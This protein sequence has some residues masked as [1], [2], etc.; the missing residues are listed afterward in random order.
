MSFWQTLA[1]DKED[2]MGLNRVETLPSHIPTHKGARGHSQASG[3]AQVSTLPDVPVRSSK[4][5]KLLPW[6]FFIGYA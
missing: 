3:Y 5:P 2:V 4:E 6:D 1:M